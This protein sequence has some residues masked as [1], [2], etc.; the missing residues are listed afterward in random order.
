ML[1]VARMA[2]RLLLDSSELVRD[3]L[4][5]R[6]HASGGFVDRDGRPDLYYTVFGIDALIA[7]S[8]DVP[9]DEIATWL[10][11]HAAGIGLDLVHLACLARSWAAIG[12]PV[13]EEV[14]AHLVDEVRRHRTPDGGYSTMPD[15]DCGTLY[16]AFLAL[17]A[18]QD[19]GVELDDVG[20][21]CDFI[22]SM[23]TA[24]GGYSNEP[25]MSVGTT[26]A[27]AAAVTALRNQ[28]REPRPG[29][30]RWLESQCHA[31]GGFL[32]MPHA[33]MPDLLSTATALHALAVLEH[34]FD[35]I[36]EPS[37]DFIDTL[38]TNEGAFHGTW[39]DDHL[40]VEYTY[41]ALLSLGHLALGAPPGT[42]GAKRGP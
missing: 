32:A 7:L 1:Q 6:R 19:A 37:L 8:A 3:F 41:Y 38:W 20:A 4:L 31:E 28:R 27:T 14:R 29:V 30:A 24:D 22:E 35:R 5:S 26:P 2:P 12:R 36:L 17:G 40:D 9:A 18:T 23:E 13:P 34:P 11:S 21:L 42:P 25:S 39:A 15:A 33:P 16:G 10:S